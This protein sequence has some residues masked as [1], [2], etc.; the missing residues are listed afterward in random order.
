MKRFLSAIAVV[1]LLSTAVGAQDLRL[2]VTGDDGAM[3]TR[4]KGASAVL[5]LDADDT[6]TAQDLIAAARADYRN[7]L[8][9]LYTLGHY[10]GAVSIR[11]DGREVAQIPPLETIAHLNSLVIT[12]TPGPAFTFR[13]AE[14][15]PLPPGAILPDGFAQGE[16]ALSRL[17]G[18]AAEA[19][20]LA[21]RDLGHAKAARSGQE[22]IAHHPSQELDVL[23]RIAPGPRL[24]FG[25]L[26]VSGN[27]A[28]RSDRIRAIAGLPEGAVYDP[29]TL[30]A[31]ADRLRR[32]GAFRSVSLIEAE[33]YGAD[34]RLPIEAQVVERLPR[35]IGAGL[36]YS[37]SEGVTTSAYWLHRNLLGG[38]ESLRLDGEISQI[39][40]EGTDYRLSAAFERPAT[41]ATLNTLRIEADAAWVH[42]PGYRLRETNATAALARRISDDLTA[43]FGIGLSEGRVE[44]ALGVQNYLRLTL[45]LSATLDR[46]DDPRDAT[47][48]YYID[49][50]ITPFAGLRGSASGVR[51][52]GDARAYRSFG[53]A[54]PVTL[55]G[56]VQIGSLV[57]PS[58]RD[59]PADDLFYSGGGGTVRGH[60]YQSL[61]V[62]A[63]GGIG[64]IGG[65]SFVGA[66]AEIRVPVRDSFG[67]VGFYDI[68]Y[69]GADPVPGRNGAYQHG[70]GLGLRYDSAL[71]PLR[72][73]VAL[74]VEPDPEWSDVHF[75]IGI[76]Q[77]F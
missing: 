72:L 69:V 24:S 43:S 16:P 3:E 50:D 10:G 63:P 7:M 12:V 34:L 51:L 64:Q 56:R 57:G 73:D 33:T 47:Q 32:S 52:Y 71:G 76:G 75:Y 13:R 2:V 55:A 39:A 45:P 22:I 66:S 18:Q 9:G 30:E 8:L 19:G 74:P 61:G 60:D 31:A 67:L 15:A 1:G 44:D 26:S 11:A 59:A 41:F 38:A 27:S 46:R 65:R 58:L 29:D 25:A 14:V 37:S 6:A 23:V 49:L 53:T 70:A 42:D 20:T 21:W 77:S 36:S 5:S 17:V 28:V 62:P 48:G 35:R 54:R 68:G 40:A 4:L